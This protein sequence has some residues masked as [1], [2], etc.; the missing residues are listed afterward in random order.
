MYGFLGNERTETRRPERTA[1]EFG[2]SFF[3]DFITT[4]RGTWC[5]VRGSAWMLCV[6][7]PFFSLTSDN[8]KVF[9]L[10]TSVVLVRFL[11]TSASV[12]LRWLGKNWSLYQNVFHSEEISLE[13]VIGQRRGRHRLLRRWCPCRPSWRRRRPG[14]WS[15]PGALPR[16]AA[17]AAGVAVPPRP[18]AEHHLLLVVARPRAAALGAPRGRGGGDAGEGAREAAHAPRAR[19]EPELS[20]LWSKIAK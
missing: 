7:V 1:A 18:R 4:I 15:A 6:F 19:G 8:F 20:L 16:P 17:G 2:L 10:L 14:S 3:S 5:V 11:K 13:S 12:T 9:S